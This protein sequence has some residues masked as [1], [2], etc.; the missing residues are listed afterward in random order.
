MM[1]RINWSHSLLLMIM[2]KGRTQNLML[3]LISMKNCL[4][5]RKGGLGT[6]YSI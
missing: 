3:L 1:R 2:L 4:R 6:G 5:R